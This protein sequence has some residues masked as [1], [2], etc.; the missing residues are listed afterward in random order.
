MDTD[1]EKG[2]H[3][4]DKK[5]NSI[6]SVLIP[7]RG[8]IATAVLI[9]VNIVIFILMAVAGV[10]IFMPDTLGLLEWGADFGPLTLTGDWWRT[11]TCNFV[12]ISIFHLVMNMYALLF[13]S[14]WL[15][16]LIGTRRMFFSYTLTGL[17]SAACS[18]LIHSDLI[19]AGASGSI[20]G[21]Y[22]IFL[23]FLFSHRI[24]KSQRQAL[25]AS[26]L[27]FVCYNLLNG[28]QSGIDNAAHVGGL[29][30]GLMLG[31]VYV[32]A[33]KQEKISSQRLLTITGEISIFLLFA[34]SI[35]GISK[36]IPSE[37]KEIREEWN[38]GAA[39][40]YL[41][42]ESTGENG[43]EYD[44]P[45]YQIATNKDWYN[46]ID[47]ESSFACKYPSNWTREE[48]SNSDFTGAVPPLLVLTNGLNSLTI[49]KVNSPNKQDFD[50]AK[51]Q[52]L[53]VMNEKE[54]DYEHTQATING[55]QYE[56][57]LRNMQAAGTDG[58]SY[59]VNQLVLYHFP[60]NKEFTLIIQAMYNDDRAKED[61]D[62]IIETIRP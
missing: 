7:R 54:A 53:K 1:L 57:I 33:D 44:L 58:T 43:E 29:V 50:G 40:E 55:I 21:L 46:F 2:L 35:F 42:G 11:F 36:N 22:G 26:I 15:E 28:M 62:N 6:L 12:H 60:V 13:I 8:F 41:A 47:T 24:E 10:G 48:V 4:G 51:E 27:V 61:L 34:T 25:L 23:A 56:K 32:F 14:L 31:Y 30:S 17:C 9:Y 19:S 59:E 3:Y 37:Y 45:P 52:L 49:T 39:Q 18:L 20:F 16:P 38:S 5:Y